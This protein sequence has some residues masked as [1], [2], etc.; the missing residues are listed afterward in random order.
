MS[1]PA[2]HHHARRV[3]GSWERVTTALEQTVGPGRPAGS[4]VKFCCPVHE[5]SAGHHD[6]SLIVK[7]LA[8]AARTKLQCQAGCDDRDVLD[9]LGLKVRDLYDRPIERG[10]GRG[11]AHQPIRPRPRQVSR[12]DRAIDAAG[13]PLTKPRKDLGRQLSAERPTATYPYARADGTIAGEVIRKEARFEHGT[14]KS[15]YQRR[16]T[17]SGMQPGGFEPL[18]FQLPRVLAAI[19][20]GEPIFI[21]EGEKDV[22]AAEQTGLTATCNAAGAGKWRP[23]H[24]EWLRG[25]RTVV[26]VADRDA[27]GYRHAEKVAASLAG[28]VERVRIVQAATGKDLADHL[29]CGHEVRELEPVAYLDPHT[30]TRAPAPV[31]RDPSP[32]AEARTVSAAASET[33][34]N[35]GGNT[36]G[37]Q[38]LAPQLHDAPVDTTPDID[39][40]GGQ[41]TRFVQLLMTQMLAMARKHVEQ[42]RAWLEDLARKDENERRE[43][44]E[45]LAVERAAAEARLRKLREGGLENASR[46]EIAAA[47]RDAAAWSAD[48]PLAREALQELGTHVQH[49]Y[50]IRLDAATG[51]VIADTPPQL[52]AALA[53]A[54]TER[55]ALAR[56]R[57]A[58]DRMVE[59]VAGQDG[60][61]QSAKEQLYAEIEA[62]RI[63]PTGKK[64]DELTKKLAEKGL[65]EQAQKVRII[66]QFL[67]QPHHVV[68]LDQLDTSDASP[69]VALQKLDAPLVDPGEEAKNRIDTMLVDYQT[70]LRHGRDTTEVRQR[71]AEA[72]AL[73]TPED[74]QTAR[75][76]GV[77]IRNNPAAEFK[78]LWPDHVDRDELTAT[79]R[80]YAVLAPRV[81]SH[82]ADAGDLDAVTG[83]QLREKTAQERRRIERAIKTG[84]GLHEL[85]RDQLTA[86]LRDIEAGR[87]TVP[88]LL[89]LDDRTA[90]M[91]DADRSDQTAHDTARHHRRKIEQ[92]LDSRQVPDGAVRQSRDEVSKLVH[93][94]T[95]LAAGRWNMADYEQRGLD[96]ALD[97]KLDALGV[98]EP[99]RNQVRNQLGEARTESAIVG[100]QAHR[101]R[102]QWAERTEK[103]AAARAAKLEYDSP[104]RR[105]GMERNLQAAGLD[106]DQ[107]AQRMAADAGRAKPPSA[108]VRHAPGERPKQPRTTQQGMGVRRT[109][110]RGKGRGERDFGR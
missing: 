21:C 90:A 32:A 109:Q 86:V 80:R 23:E 7:Y 3:E 106:E 38:F 63:N 102:N 94:H 22:L 37:E 25:A 95:Q 46:S 28:L 70:T 9:K 89:L 85:E 43:A 45:R 58:Q 18:P 4:W 53:A 83:K 41:W 100:K 84:K 104:Q 6:P 93:A 76:R 40:A 77:Q 51:Q 57:K 64:L 1:A 88:E 16:W 24:A 71:L 50:G 34:L 8:D 35:P 107:I 79:V 52:A 30:P 59:L 101:I 26:I 19:E 36:V 91:V 31:S 82:A 27:P 56:V 92:T 110:H 55:A 69:I 81:E 60:L 67:G 87:T 72:V 14:G 11:R 42:R 48:S 98:P 5:A 97:T 39:H 17:E 75:D 103:V 44:E 49:R 15:F 10:Q 66:A 65:N 68:P 105:A 29:A 96:E 73:M 12:A 108:A 20:A 33:H 61:D 78:P 99:V 62:W 2:R 74:Q 47:V 54:E 13:L